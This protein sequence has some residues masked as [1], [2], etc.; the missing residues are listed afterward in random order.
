[1]PR[2]RGNFRCTC[3]LP[4]SVQRSMREHFSFAANPD[5]DKFCVRKQQVMWRILPQKGLNPE[6]LRIFR[7]IRILRSLLRRNRQVRDRLTRRN[8]NLGRSFQIPV[9]SNTNTLV[10]PPIL[11]QEG[12]DHLRGDS[13][14]LEASCTVDLSVGLR[15]VKTPENTD[16]ESA[17]VAPSESNEHQP[18]VKL[19][20]R[21]SH[22]P[23][24]KRSDRQG[25]TTVQS[26]D[27][28]LSPDRSNR[29]MAQLIGDLED[30]SAKAQEFLSMSFLSRSLGNYPRCT[31][32]SRLRPGLVNQN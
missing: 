23:S 21:R 20:T 25:A 10:D 13:P 24:V 1:M 18:G 32:S 12:V 16:L 7:W 11:T 29:A 17:N 27:S 28:L 22:S 6:V 3:T 2:V 8:P 9:I 5:S 26:L 31:H 15:L 30:E 14:G 19:T 4:H